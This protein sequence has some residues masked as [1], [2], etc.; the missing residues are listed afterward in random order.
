MHPPRKV[1]FAC[2]KQGFF[3][4]AAGGNAKF[5][6]PTHGMRDARKLD[7]NT[8]AEHGCCGVSGS[9]G[10]HQRD[11]RRNPAALEPRACHANPAKMTDSRLP[12]LD[13]PL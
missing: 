13:K 3:P 12:Q 9:L 6:T 10:E 4:T 7:R 8:V 2:G 1:D 11:E 5:E